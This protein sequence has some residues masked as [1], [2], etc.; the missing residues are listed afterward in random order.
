[1]EVERESREGGEG[2]VWRR[3]QGKEAGVATGAIFV[4]EK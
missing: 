4:L 2:Q 3:Q 1:V